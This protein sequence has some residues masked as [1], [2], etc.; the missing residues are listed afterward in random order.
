M[1]AVN[2]II[3]VPV[4]KNWRVCLEGIIGFSVTATVNYLF[5][6]RVGIDT[7]D[8]SVPVLICLLFL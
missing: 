5:Y 6:G 2:M 1:A 7:V 3:P 8:A 4:V